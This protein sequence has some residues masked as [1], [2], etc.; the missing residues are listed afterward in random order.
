MDNNIRNEKY[1]GLTDEEMI[2]LFRDG[3]QEAME[4]LLEKYKGMVLGKAKSMYILGGDS[5]DLIQEGMLGLFKAVRDFDCGRDASFR[6][7]AQLCVTRQLYTA[8]K[9]SARKKHLPLNSAVSLSSPLREENGDERDEELLDFLEADP[10]SN[11]EAYLI[12]QEETE[13]LEEMI[14]KELSPLEKQVLELYLTGMGYVE[15]AH[16]LNRDEK[17]TDNALQRI[18]AKTRACLRKWRNE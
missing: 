3:D 16:V 1:S 9:A 15:I 17:S 5:E 11:P 10:S 2:S 8:V 7:F 6:T 12:G 4:K 14:E 13:R 18:R